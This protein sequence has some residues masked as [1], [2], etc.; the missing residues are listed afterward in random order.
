MVLLGQL[1]LDDEQR[2][3]Q[4]LKEWLTERSLTSPAYANYLQNWGTWH[5]PWRHDLESG[6][7]GSDAANKEPLA[8]AT[9]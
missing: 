8:S 5:N 3:V 6:D 1:K 4:D 9:S 2:L 7:R